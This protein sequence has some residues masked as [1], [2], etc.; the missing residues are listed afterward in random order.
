MPSSSLSIREKTLSSP[1]SSTSDQNSSDCFATS[2][3]SSFVASFKPSI[4][5]ASGRI[6]SSSDVSA[7]SDVTS[8]PVT[9][10][11]SVF[12]ASAPSTGA[13]VVASVAGCSVVADAS[14]ETSPSVDGVVP[15]LPDVSE[16]FKPKPVKTSLRLSRV[17]LIPSTM[18]SHDNNSFF[19]RTPSLSVSRLIYSALIALSSTIE[20]GLISS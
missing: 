20:N 7:P 18:P 3:K 13:S 11:C 12:A 1:I 9:S 15:L 16:T 5:T 19:V 14:A 17:P 8:S 2:L 10:G 4:I 6:S